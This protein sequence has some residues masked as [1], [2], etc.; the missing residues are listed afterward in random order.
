M[1]TPEVI[2]GESTAADGFVAIRD[3]VIVGVGSGDGAEWEA[4]R[5]V[6]LGDATLAPGFVDAHIHPIMGLQLTRGVD[7][8]GLQSV[9]RR[10][11]AALA[12]HIA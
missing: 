2:R 7:L 5:V 11:A 12:A 4:E 6:D 10:C 8:S 9:G 1:L 3:G